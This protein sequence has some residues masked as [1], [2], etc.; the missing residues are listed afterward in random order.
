M[1]TSSK[2][3]ENEESPSTFESIKKDIQGFSLKSKLTATKPVH[4][5]RITNLDKHYVERLQA[6]ELAN[7]KFQK[8]FILGKKRTLL[9]VYSAHVTSRNLPKFGKLYVG[10]GVVC[11]KC[12][13]PGISTVMILPIEDIEKCRFEESSKLSFANLTFDIKGHEAINFEFNGRS[14]RDDCMK[15][16]DSQLGSSNAELL[17][18]DFSDEYIALL[19][20]YSLENAL[21]DSKPSEAELKALVI[22]DARIKMY[23]DGLRAATGIDTPILLGETLLTTTEVKPSTSLHF[24]LLTIGSRGDVQPFVALGKGL[25]SEG[26]TVTIATHEEF[27]DFV[28]K[29]GL[30]FR[31]V[32]GN[33]TDLML[34][35]VEHG[36]MSVAF[37]KEAGSKFRGWINDLLR[38]SWDACQ[39]ADIIIESPSAMAGAHVAEAMGVAY[40]RAFTMPWTR[41][42]AYP[43]AF[44]VPDKPM[45]GSYNYFTH[46]LFENVFWTGISGQV[47]KWRVDDLKLPKTN[48]KR[49]QQAKIPFLYNISPCVF[50]PATDFYDWVKVTGYWFLNEGSTQ[51]YQPPSDLQDFMDKAKRDKKPLVYIGFGSIVVKDSKTLTQSVVD[52]VLKADVRCIL[53]KGWLDRHTDDKD[54]HKSEIE[55]PSEVYSLESIPH[56]WLFPRIDVA[57]HHGGSGTT[58]ASVRLGI[59]TIIK[60]FFGD[61]FFFAADIEARGIG[62]EL[63]QLNAD[64]LSK[65]LTK[66]ATDKEMKKR[67]KEFGEKVGHEDG[68]TRAIVSIYEQFEYSRSLISA[69]QVYNAKHGDASSDEE[70][71]EGKEEED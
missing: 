59:P 18:N 42:H 11:F 22:G 39:G 52:G 54:A 41:T 29:N 35:M 37:L 55:L 46:V 6:R 28:T 31:A 33:P 49:L 70:G 61:Q 7:K 15:I 5:F 36:T 12:S 50:P 63:K 45:G 10:L 60:P 1:Q 44:L 62:L 57:V 65:A 16:I 66:A 53:N 64:S 30:M 48:L 27:E 40:M 69:K 2:S 8:R 51:D 26:H 32:A 13:L 71:E 67:A 38:S 14:I 43:H 19:S 34:L 47:N 25:I 21:L 9:A 68:V 3:L 20:E 4:F 23:E 56:D 24:V 17:K 58:G